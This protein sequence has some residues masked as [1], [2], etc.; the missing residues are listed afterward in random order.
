[1]TRVSPRSAPA[2][3]SCAALLLRL[4][5]GAALAMGVAL[6]QS[7]MGQA[8]KKDKAPAAAFAGFGSNSKEPIKID[9]ARLEVVNKEQ[10]ALYSGDV[11]VVQ[12]QTTLRC[13]TLKIFY[14]Q[15]GGKDGQ[16]AAPAAGGNAQSAIKKLECEGPM[17]VL[18][19]TQTATAQRGVYEAASEQLT[20]TGKV[21]IADGENVQAGERAIYN[22]KTGIA[23]MD[24]GKAGGRVRTLLIPGTQPGADK[25][26]AGADKKA[27]TN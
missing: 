2:V 18:S 4:A 6:P 17:S 10:Y 20:L 7:A 27:N 1:M 21:I 12:G 3:P 11:V 25:K 5:L 22:V 15:K 8:A 26:G 23:T 13:V 19:G 9:A 14:E 24:G 16:P